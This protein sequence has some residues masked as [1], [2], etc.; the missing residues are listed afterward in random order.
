MEDM[1]YSVAVLISSQAIASNFRNQLNMEDLT[2]V[3]PLWIHWENWRN[4]KM[5]K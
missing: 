5:I 3:L 2:R 1:S 4:W